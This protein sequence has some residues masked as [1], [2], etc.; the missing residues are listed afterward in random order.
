MGHDDNS[1]AEIGNTVSCIVLTELYKMNATFGVLLIPIDCN[2]L[3]KVFCYLALWLT[4]PPSIMLV[5]F[6]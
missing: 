5:L 6:N 4:S 3:L 1:L 2:F